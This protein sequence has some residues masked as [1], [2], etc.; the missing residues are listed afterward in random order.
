V[1]QRQPLR[2]HGR[3]RRALLLL[4]LLGGAGSWWPLRHAGTALIVTQDV[5]SPDAIIMLA[6]HEW[7]RLPAAAA[8]ARR[9]PNAVLLLTVPPT[10]T[11]YNC[12]R[13]NERVAW[14]QTE[15]VSRARVRLL[16]GSTTNTHGEALAARAQLAGTPARRLLVVTSPYHTRRALATFRTVFATTPVQID[17]RPASG[18]RG[19]PTHWWHSPYDRHY[20]LYEWAAILKYRLSYGVPLVREAP[21]AAAES[22]PDP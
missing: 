10:I 21:A 5:G 19:D 20:V 12:Y 11:P 16:T 17:V 2:A 22:R 9:Y 7:E 1:E 6:S 14:L 8:E 3:W 13:C 18:A 15:G 4:L